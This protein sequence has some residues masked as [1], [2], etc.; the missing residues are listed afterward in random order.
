MSARDSEIMNWL[1][2]DGPQIT[3]ST[4]F[5]N[6]FAEKL[7]ENGIDVARVGT[8]VPI[9]HPQVFSFTGLWEAGKGASERRKSRERGHSLAP[10][11]QSDQ[12]CVRRPWSGTLRSHRAGGE[13]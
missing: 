13:G 5:L 11:E 8:G 9:L 7:L 12:D 4:A 3:D 6:A 1:L 10:A 2:R